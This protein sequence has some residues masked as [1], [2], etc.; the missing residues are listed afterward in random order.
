MVMEFLRSAGPART[1]FLDVVIRPASNLVLSPLNSLE[2]GGLRT[3]N[4]R[5]TM[6]APESYTATKTTA[7]ARHRRAGR[8]P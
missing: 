8:I 6:A 4:G 1:K 7:F 3:A 5:L 2:R